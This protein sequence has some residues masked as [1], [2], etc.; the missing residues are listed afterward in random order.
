VKIKFV[1]LN[2]F[3]GN[4]LDQCADFLKRE[5][6]DIFVLQEVYD[7]GD[8]RLETKYR[9]L[10]ILKN[11]FSSHH[12]YFSPEYFR[13][14]K[15][16]RIDSGNAIFTRSPI[17]KRQTDFFS[18]SYRERTKESFEEFLNSPRNLQ[19]VQIKTEDTIIHIFNT[20]GI[21]GTH[22]R[23]TSDR[24][25]MGELIAEEVKGKEKAVLAG[26]FNISTDTRTIGL[27]KRQLKNV[28]KD[29]LRS[30]F[31]MKIKTPFVKK[32]HFFNDGDIT[33]F[34]KA[35]VDMIFVSEDI[36][37]VRHYQPKVDIS[38]HYPLAATLEI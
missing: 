7:G 35:V 11:H 24:I 17:I 36:K 32:L 18:G 5:N 4:Y 21:W 13:A 12:C 26:D 16:R 19:Q 34:S 37:V 20:H 38:D 9:S 27:I 10:E 2:V 31:N 15:G 23:D 6:P 1:T 8:T 28:F 22:G 33:S 30:T 29:E 14:I 3:N 25:N